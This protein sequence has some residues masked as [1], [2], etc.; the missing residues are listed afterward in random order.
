MMGVSAQTAGN[1]LLTNAQTTASALRLGSLANALGVKGATHA[2]VPFSGGGLAPGL[3]SVGAT[4]P[5]P[6][7]RLA[8]PQGESN[9]VS[10]GG[11]GPL[12]TGH[13]LSASNSPYFGQLGHYPFAFNAQGMIGPTALPLQAN[14]PSY[15]GLN[16]PGMYPPPITGVNPMI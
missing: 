14:F 7:T 4:S 11:F 8:S 5:I 3:A 6:Y 15:A 2:F 12:T 10:L 1:P 9:V 16:M 13:M